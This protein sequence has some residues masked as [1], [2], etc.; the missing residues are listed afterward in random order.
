MADLDT[1]NEE[2]VERVAARYGLAAR[3][4]EPLVATETGEQVGAYRVLIGAELDK[5]IAVDIALADGEEPHRLQLLYAFS[6]PTTLVPHLAVEWTRLDPKS[7]RVGLVVDLLPRVDLSVN[8]RYADECYGPLTEI[9]NDVWTIDNVRAM[10]VGPRRATAFSPWRISVTAPET[11]VGS[12]AVLVDRYIDHWIA[13][14]SGG[15][16][17]NVDPV[18]SDPA[19]LVQHDRYHRD[20]LFD[21]ESDPRWARIYRLIGPNQ[22]A[23]LRMA[24]RSQEVR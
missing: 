13:I 16:G 15:V 12:L 20:G 6:R 8:Q 3:N 18:A 5:A 4:D 21:E 2:T 19:K 10:F 24:L 11:E 22:G 7:D 23:E 14:M 9:W 1:F 17:A